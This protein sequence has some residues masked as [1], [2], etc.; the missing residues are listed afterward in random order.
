MPTQ[1]QRSIEVVDESGKT[2][3]VAH[4]LTGLHFGTRRVVR[5][6]AIGAEPEEV[7]WNCVCDCGYVSAVRSYQIRKGLAASCNT[8]ANLTSLPKRQLSR[9]KRS[10]T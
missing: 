3:R 8:C 1:K 7:R 10:T 9:A 5:M 2:R 4:D 6:V